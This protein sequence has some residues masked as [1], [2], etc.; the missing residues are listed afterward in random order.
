MS[1][2]PELY[3]LNPANLV[4]FLVAEGPCPLNNAIKHVR[5]AFAD[6]SPDVQTAAVAAATYGWLNDSRTSTRFYAVNA[7]ARNPDWPSRSDFP[8]TPTGLVSWQV[9]EWVADRLSRDA[10]SARLSDPDPAAAAAPAPIYADFELGPLK[11]P[12]GHA[13]HPRRWRR[14]VPGPNSCWRPRKADAPWPAP[15]LARKPGCAYNRPRK[16]RKFPF[17]SRLRR[18]SRKR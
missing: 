7:N 1:K 3:Q 12:V 16:R 5:N 10:N 17:R 2:S 4:V 9:H 8:A 18:C 6:S 11:C 15:G 13:P 14:G